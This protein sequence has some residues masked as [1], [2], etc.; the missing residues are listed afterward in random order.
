MGKKKKWWHNA[1][2]KKKD[3]NSKPSNGEA[4]GQKSVSSRKNFQEGAKQLKKP[5]HEG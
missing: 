5:G 4:Q 2:E 1:R 3:K